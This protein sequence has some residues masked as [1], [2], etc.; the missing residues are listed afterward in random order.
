MKALETN[1]PAELKEGRYQLRGII[2][3]GSMGRT[4]LADDTSSGRKVA[5]KALYPSRLAT[6]KDLELFQRE[7]EILQ[8]L[9][10]PRIPSYVDAFD[11]GE[12]ES[13]RY[14][15]VQTYVEGDTLRAR[16]Q[17]DER[18]SEDEVVALAKQILVVLRYMHGC[19]PPVVHRD[20]K[21]DNVI[22][23]ASDG[24]PTLVDFGAVRE[25]VRLTM[26]GG[27]TII[28]TYGYMPPEQ[29]MGK[30]VPGSDIY[31]LGITLLELLTHQTPQDLHGEEAE[32]LIEAANLTDEFGRVLRRM[33]APTLTDRYT[34]ADQVLADL[35]AVT[36]G[37]ALVHAGKL[38]SDI[39]LR[40]KEKERALKKASTPS[41][42][43]LIYMTLVALAVS[44]AIGG[45]IILVQA[46]STS[47]QSGFVV[48]GVLSA[49]GLLT[50]LV[51]L[52]KRYTHDAWEPPDAS[53]VRSRGEITRIDDLF[54]IDEYGSGTE[55]RNQVI[56]YRIVYEFSTA[57]GTFE[58]SQSVPKSANLDRYEPGTQ[59]DVY[60]RKGKPEWH[61]IQD[62]VHDPEDAMSTLFSAARVHTPE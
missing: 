14:Y 52:G 7:A 32:R 51:L 26:G 50:T 56:G 5:V 38:E 16:L 28:G 36:G 20:I 19:E 62:F 24:Q 6:L 30:A 57:R 23:R 47:F 37:G 21:P 46:I 15:L 55:P 29:L 45:V 39:E 60:Y 11:I 1:D 27:S 8:K 2:G 13:A 17:H 33:C 9:D 3:E 41:I 12:G 40:A 25:V 49:A 22:L 35:D 58:Y 48:A 61:E 10:H 4:Y 53:W 31:S 42:K 43:H 59:F 18:W 44:A 34:D 54:P